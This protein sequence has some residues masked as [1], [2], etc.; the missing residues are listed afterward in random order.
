LQGTAH[1]T[2]GSA[3][4]VEESPRR[5]RAGR[6]LPFTLGESIA[7]QRLFKPGPVLA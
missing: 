1:A 4:S 7:N 6:N 5:H 2:Q 3:A